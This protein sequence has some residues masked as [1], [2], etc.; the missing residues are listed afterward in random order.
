MKLKL[1]KTFI[2]VPEINLFS[3]NNFYPI[4]FACF[5]LKVFLSFM[6]IKNILNTLNKLWN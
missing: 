2:I 1:L 4:T 6:R 5:S 3:L